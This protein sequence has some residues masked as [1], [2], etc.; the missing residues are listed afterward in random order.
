MKNEQHW[1]VLNFA[2]MQDTIENTSPMVTNRW[3]NTSK[4]HALAKI[5]LG[6]PPFILHQQDIQPMALPSKG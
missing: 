6:I 2:D 1:P 4:V 5:T 3:K